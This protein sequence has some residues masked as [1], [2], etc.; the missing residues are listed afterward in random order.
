[1]ATFTFRQTV[2]MFVLMC[3]FSLGAGESRTD[4]FP[5]AGTVSYEERVQKQPL[6]TPLDRE[7]LVLPVHCLGGLKPM[8]FEAGAEM[9]WRIDPSWV[10]WKRIPWRE[11]HAEWLKY[12]SDKLSAAEGA[13]LLAWCD[14]KG[15]DTCAG[16]ETRRLVR[17]GSK[18]FP[19]GTYKNLLTRLL[20][21]A[22][23][24]QPSWNFPLPLD[25]EWHVLRDRNGHHRWPMKRG[26][27]AF[28]YDLV[29]RRGGRCYTGSGRR[30]TDHFAWNQ[31]IR[32]QADG[33][34]RQAE[35]KHP[36][37]PIGRLGA[38][39]AANHISVYYGAG[40]IVSYGHLKQ[41]SVTLK[42]GDRVVAGQIIGRVGNSGASGMPHLHFTFFDNAAI[43]KP[44]RYRIE[45]QRANR[46]IEV[47]D[48]DLE[49][50][51]YVRNRPGALPPEKPG[52]AGDVRV[53]DAGV[54][55]DS[56]G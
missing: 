7:A 48:R 40:A 53:P 52:G 47:A 18:A 55:A 29:V 49:E 27:T 3:S 50:G 10:V 8:K 39:N 37:L 19:M 20:R 26:G 15:L 41:G 46:W 42:P 23:S 4:R 1:M 2:S 14:K 45:V 9:K 28:A 35:G 33:V 44:G 11:E 21:V 32:A 17:M 43:S 25:G 13:A 16:Y 24:E 31:P 36:D 5:D 34:V 51:T 30:L 12:R 38:F 56:K 22:G 6:A 54:R